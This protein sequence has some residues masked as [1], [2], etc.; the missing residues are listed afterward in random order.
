MYVNWEFPVTMRTTPTVY[1]YARDG[2]ADK[3]KMASGNK[4]ASLLASGD[5]NAE[6][7]GTDDVAG[8]DRSLYFHALAVAEIG[9]K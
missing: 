6:V 8:V 1:W 4:A 5:R 3:V 9:G 7:S 2:T